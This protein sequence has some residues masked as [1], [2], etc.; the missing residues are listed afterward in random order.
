MHIN[1]MGSP[2]VD[3]KYIIVISLIIA[4]IGFA[5]LQPVYAQDDNQSSQ[6][7]DS[8]T[9]QYPEKMKDRQ[10]WE[11]ILSSPGLLINLPFT[12]ALTITEIAVSNLYQPQVVGWM[13]DVTTSDDSLRA[14]R[15][16]YSSRSGLG[17]KVYQKDLLN[18]GSYI[19]LAAKAGLSNRQ[20]Y[21]LRFEQFDLYRKTLYMDLILGYRFL[22]EE[23]FYG[24]GPDTK[25]EAQT[26]YTFERGWAIL[27]LGTRLTG[28]IDLMGIFSLEQS[29]VLGR[30]VTDIP[31]TRDMYTL[32]ELPGLE[33]EV[34]IMS[35]RLNAKYDSRDSKGGPRRGQLIDLSWGMFSQI[36]D[37]DYGFWQAA[38]DIRQYVHIFYGRTLVFRLAGQLT[39]PVSG[40]EIPFYNLSDLGPT[41]TIRGFSRSR[42][43]DNDMVL[44]SIEYRY[45]IYDRN[46]SVIDA[47]LFVD[48]GQVSH[49]LFQE[50][51]A[52][53]LQFG[54]G[55]GFRVWSGE[56]ESLNLILGKSK[57]R[58][59]ID[60]VV[61][62]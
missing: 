1:K 40:K 45:P 43:R 58:F 5:G 24:I 60:F 21:Q 28:R 2:K 48:A 42:F 54:F 57:E 4:F 55:G 53:N 46:N 25:E 37:D 59:R 52:D 16:A 23:R 17:L 20:K 6:S 11:W 47:F 7:N 12:I 38:A 31:A 56:V 30:K 62:N 15:P 13:Y 8:T 18:K 3:L 39:E 9:T 50:F 36:D 27:N 34:K 14:I 29:S 41:E 10:T 19:E 32:A 22:H 33:S 49:D 61:N 35:A 26:S 44:G 51:E